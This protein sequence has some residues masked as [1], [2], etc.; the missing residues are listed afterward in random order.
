MSIDEVPRKAVSGRSPDTIRLRTLFILVAILAA[1]LSVSAERIRT[2][3]QRRTEAM[4][5]Q[6]EIAAEERRMVAHHFWKVHAKLLLETEQIRGRIKLE[7]SRR[8]ELV[9]TY[10]PEEVT[11]MFASLRGEPLRM[12]IDHLR[13]NSARAEWVRVMALIAEWAARH[14]AEP[15]PPSPPEPQS[16]RATVDLEKFIPAE[17]R[18]DGPRSIPSI[19]KIAE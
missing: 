18:D 5:R 2:E 19:V 7:E 13:R 4:R 3:R 17:A 8:A 6:I 14:P 12:H 16:S 15:F 1:I 9:K 11:R 10:G